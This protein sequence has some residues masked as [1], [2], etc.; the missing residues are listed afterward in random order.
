MSRA[1]L[2]SAGSLAGVALVA[3]LLSG[4]TPLPTVNAAPVATSTAN[5]TVII[6]A[7]SPSPTPSRSP[8]PSPSSSSGGGTG[9]GTGGGAGSTSTPAPH[10]SDGSPVPPAQPSDD[11]PRLTLDKKRVGVGEWIMATGSGFT[12]G[13]KVQFVLYPGAIVIGSFVAD[14]GGTVTARF[15]MPD[16]IRS[17]SH[18]LEATGWQSG[19][20]RNAELTVSSEAVVA[21]PWLWWVFVVL[22]VLLVSLIALAAYY[23]ESIRGWFGG[24]SAPAKAT[25]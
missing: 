16:D 7:V 6:P 12:P 22:G 9:G 5:V 25:P 21:A 1:A 10:N 14:A 11:A 17:G 24:A 4:M 15:V 18:V 2:A 8:S 3:A 23:R 19:F 20:V 13:E